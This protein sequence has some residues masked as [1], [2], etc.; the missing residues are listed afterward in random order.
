MLITNV[1][2]R[3]QPLIRYELSDSVTLTPGPGPAGWP[4]HRLSTVD[5]RSGDIVTL[6]A[7]G[8]G[9]V[10]VHPMSRIA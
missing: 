10:R 1:V 2:N 5:G 8:G 6:P 4:F 7:R 9:T 3:V